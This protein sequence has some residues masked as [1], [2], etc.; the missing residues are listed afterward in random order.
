MY[1]GV[2]IS[3]ICAKEALFQLQFA[4]FLD[5]WQHSTGTADG[6]F[7]RGRK[8]RRTLRGCLLFRTRNSMRFTFFFCIRFCFTKNFIRIRTPK[9]QSFSGIT[10]DFQDSEKSPFCDACSRFSIPSGPST[11][12]VISFRCTSSTVPSSF[13]RTDSANCR[14]R[15]PG[16]TQAF[17]IKILSIIRKSK[18]RPGPEE[19]PAFLCISRFSRGCPPHR[20][21]GLHGAACGY[22]Q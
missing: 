19:A 15:E 20:D 13:F 11:A 18:Y 5:S 1:L 7:L 2:N 12:R 3:N 9:I 4:S 17:I 14:V 8:L 21:G 6:R 10:S 16:L 22:N